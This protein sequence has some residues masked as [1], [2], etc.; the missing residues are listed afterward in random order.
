M[1][2]EVLKKLVFLVLLISIGSV[3]AS[4]DEA[5][6]VEIILSNSSKPVIYNFIDPGDS[7]ETVSNKDKIIFYSAVINILNPTKKKY[8]V[9]LICVDS[10]NHM[11]FKGE[12]KRSLL[13]LEDH[14][15]NDI[16]KRIIQL[17]E[18]DPKP[19]AM[20]EGQLAPLENNRDYFI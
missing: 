5:T 17:L 13:R 16:I 20:V 8:D 3:K 14:M 15:G 11:I 1:K 10:K 9:E 18:F 2:K 6:A 19:G 7:V 12:K 4:S